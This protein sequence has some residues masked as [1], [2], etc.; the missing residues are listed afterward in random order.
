MKKVLIPLADGFEEIETMTVI[1]VLRRA[2]LEVISAG[3]Q[4]G[5]LKG[6]RG[7]NL[8]PDTTLEA[9]LKDSYDAVVLVGGQPGVNNLRADKR[10]LAMVQKAVEENKLVGAICAAPL[11]LRDAGLIEGR[12]LTSYPGIRDELSGCDY[13]EDR[14]VQDGRLLTS[15]GPGTAMEFA[16]ALVEQ[17]VSK[18]KTDELKQAMLVR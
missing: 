16:L 3:I 13:R 10:V 12:R 8:V 9:A 2:G 14:L 4:K 17:L 7:V 18:E 11:I 1:D 5:P 15:R 6:S